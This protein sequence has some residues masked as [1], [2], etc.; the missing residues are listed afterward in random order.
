MGYVWFLIIFAVVLISMLVLMV[1]MEDGWRT[2]RCPSCHKRVLPNSNSTLRPGAAFTHNCPVDGFLVLYGEAANR[3]KVVLFKDSSFYKSQKI[4][5]SHCNS[6]AMQYDLECYVCGKPP[7][8]NP[9]HPPYAG[10]TFS[11]ELPPDGQRGVCS[12][13]Q[14]EMVT[15]GTVCPQCLAA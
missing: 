8:Q 7:T 9:T 14:C 1:L 6:A 15:A 13:C 12:T 3:G 11:R 2:P 5:C 10:W 4:R